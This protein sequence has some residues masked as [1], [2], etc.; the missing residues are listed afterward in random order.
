MAVQLPA[1]MRMLND[2]ATVALAQAATLLGGAHSVAE[3]GLL[4]QACEDLETAAR[5]LR[6]VTGQVDT[7]VHG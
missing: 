4:L 7:P 2:A 5:L 3:I 6:I 1:G